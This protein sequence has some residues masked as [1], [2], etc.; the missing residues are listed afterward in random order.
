MCLLFVA[1]RPQAH[2]RLVVAANRDEFHQR[3]AL[4]AAPWQDVPNVVGGRDLQG[5]GGWLAVATGGRFGALTNVREP[6]RRMTGA[7][8]RGSLVSDFVCSTQDTHD[9]LLAMRARADAYAGF[10]LLAAD[11]R[12][13][14]LLT[15]RPEPY[16]HALSPG[17]YGISNGALDDEWPKIRRGKMR[18]NAALTLPEPP[19]DALFEL[20]ADDDPAPDAEL[21]DTGV[22]L[23]AERLL[24]PA[25]IRHP[26]YGTRCSTV[27]LG[28]ADGAMRLVE[29]R[30][31]A[32]GRVTGES[33]WTLLA[34]GH[35]MKTAA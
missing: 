6:G 19:I 23:E 1:W 8:S 4:P 31:D 34:D 28:D 5:G 30:F 11:A 13:L 3:P 10:N 12:G 7:P 17:L 26:Q 9:L 32:E 20:L 24:S 25:F 2:Y 22:G 27:V 18:L 35:V 16:L 29:R 33:D 21:P 15:N 14:W